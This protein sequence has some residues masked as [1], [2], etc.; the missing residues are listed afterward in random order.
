MLDAWQWYEDRSPGLGD[1]FIDS[2]YRKIIQIEIDPGKG[3]QRK[4]NYKEML[5]KI[6]PYLIIYRVETKDV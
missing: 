6:F 5:L 1:R 2:V 3:M 4:H